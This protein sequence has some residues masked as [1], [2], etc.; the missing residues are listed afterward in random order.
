MINIASDMTELLKSIIE[1]AIEL[2]RADAGEIYLWNPA[3]EELSLSI[4]S[5]WIEP[6]AGVTLKIGEGIAGRIVKT[7]KPMIIEDYVKW[8]GRSKV[9]INHPPFISVLGVPMLGRENLIGVLEIDVDARKHHFDQNDIRLAMIFANVA[10]IAIENEKLYG[11]LQE[12]SNKLQHTLERE[13]AQRTTELVLRAKQL[14]TTAKVSKEITSILDIGRLLPRV[15]DLIQT[16]FGHYLINIYLINPQSNLLVLQASSDQKSNHGKHQDST[17][18]IDADSII[19]KAALTNQ[20]ILLSDSRKQGISK[21][22]STKTKSEL[23]IPLR[24]SERVLGILDIQSDKTNS[25]SQDDVT[26]YQSLGD[27]IGI[28]IE[29]A[30][31]YDQSRILAA[32]EE[33]NR[34]ARDLH[35]AVTQTLFSASLITDVLPGIWSEDPEKGMQLLG[36]V[37][38]LT[39]GALAE[40][41]TLLMELRPEALIEAHLSDILNQYAEA[42]TGRTGIPVTVIIDQDFILPPDV[43]VGLYRIVQESLNNT[44]RHACATEARIH[45]RSFFTNPQGLKNQPSGVELIISDNGCGFDPEKVSFDHFGLKFMIERAEAIGAKMAIDSKIGIG[46]IISVS[47]EIVGE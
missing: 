26:L 9:F 35:D 33:R 8:K 44:Y 45:L 37:R 30:H 47:L 20:A 6:Y 41:R 17:L 39:R 12:Q 13:V 42:F 2:L 34:L 25:F 24:I 46:T 3:R 23:F 21:N 31:L 19:G 38:Q 22:K 27:Q 1:W 11:E 18:T 29:N 36:N 16:T 4:G 32:H 14:E 10:A 28:A 7:N 43:K 15:I 40:M 5:G